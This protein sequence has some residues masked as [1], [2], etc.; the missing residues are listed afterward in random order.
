MNV[1]WT[2]GLSKEDADTVKAEFLNSS[3][4]RSRLISMLEDYKKELERNAEGKK[5]YD[6]PN[7]ALKQADLVGSKRTISLIIE[8][9]K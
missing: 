5:E 9:L 1:R 8:M 3:F 2:K 7:W 4:T 6:S